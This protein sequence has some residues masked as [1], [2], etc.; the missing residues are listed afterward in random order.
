MGSFFLSLLVYVAFFAL[1]VHFGNKAEPIL[2][3]AVATAKIVAITLVVRLFLGYVIGI[4][5][6]GIANL[7]RALNGHAVS[8][9]QLAQSLAF[10]LAWFIAVGCLTI[11]TMKSLKW[12][13]W[14]AGLFILACI[15]RVNL[16]STSQLLESRIKGLDARVVVTLTPDQLMVMLCG[17]IK[18]VSTG[19]FQA[20]ALLLIEDYQKEAGKLQSNEEFVSR[21]KQ[22]RR[23]MVKLLYFEEEANGSLVVYPKQY[24]RFRVWPKI[25]QL[26]TV[27][28]RLLFALVVSLV[29]GFLVFPRLNKELGEHTKFVSI[30]TFFILII[31]SVL[32]SGTAVGDVLNNIPKFL[33]GD[34]SSL[35]STRQGV[36]IFLGGLLGFALLSGIAYACFKGK[37]NTIVTL[38]AVLAVAWILWYNYG[39]KP[40]P[41]TLYESGHMKFP[42]VGKDWG[43]KK[44]SIDSVT[45]LIHLWWSDRGECELGMPFSPGQSGRPSGGYPLI[46]WLKVEEVKKLTSAE[47]HQLGIVIDQAGNISVPKGLLGIR[48]EVY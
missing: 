11:P 27:F 18:N 45:P 10:E 8:G 22:F 9:G 47:L 43:Q 37:T 20:Q 15:L 17:D 7:L 4:P 24:L 16:P 13:G 34:F 38:L 21:T 33:F 32:L 5:F 2:Q 31:G 39:P 30:I 28:E 40:S 48:Y 26:A 12:V 41:I 1:L 36:Y 19:R 6:F 25:A 42:L 23:D 46:A 3:R 14:A 35:L 44:I 29:F